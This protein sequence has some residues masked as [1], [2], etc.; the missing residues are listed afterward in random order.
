MERQ[1]GDFNFNH[2]QDSEEATILGVRS[3]STRAWGGGIEKAT[4]HRTRL[5]NRRGW[6]VSVLGYTADGK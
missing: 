1:D 6:R 2:G 3:G 5:V 4:G